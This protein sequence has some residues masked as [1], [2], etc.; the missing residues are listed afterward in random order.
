MKVLVCLAEAGEVVP[1]ERLIQTVWTDTF[2]TD[3]VLIRSISELR[4]VFNDDPKQ[5]HVIETIPK[6]GYRLLIPA[7]PVTSAPGN[8]HH[9][10][11]G[12][13]ASAEESAIHGPRIWRQWRWMWIALSAVIVLLVVLITGAWFQRFVDAHHWTARAKEGAVLAV[14]PFQN[15]NDDPDREYFA[16]GLTAEMISQLGRLPSDKISVIAWNSMRRYR[17]TKK[18]DEAI[19]AELRANYLLEG[20]VRR[21]G[22]HV[23]ITAEL[24]HV[25]DR[26]HIWANSYDGEL[27]DVLNLQTRLASEIAS[28]IRLSLTP[29]EQE[30]LA[31]TPT[32]N[33]EGYDAYLRGKFPVEG[34]TG[35]AGIRSN[36]ANLQRSI[37]L[38]PG[39]ASGYAALATQ[40]RVLSSYGWVPRN[41]VYGTMRDA[42]EMALK[43]DPD[44]EEA[45]HELA[46]L[47]WRFDWNFTGA[48]EEFK[49]AV[50]LNPSDAMAHSEYALLLKSLGRYDESLREGE[51]AL[52]S[53]PLDTYSLVNQ[54]TV[55]ALKGDY[56]AA[57]D[58]FSKVERVDPQSPY[59]HERLGQVLL[60]QKKDADAI[61]E[62]EAACASSHDQPEKLAWLA[63]ALAGSG[64]RDET[65]RILAKLTHLPKERYISPFHMSLPYIALGD[66][67][68]AIGWLEKAYQDHDEWLVYLKV[69]PEF[70]PLRDDP[71]F[72]SLV[73]RIGFQ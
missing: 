29:V 9:A 14:L 34:L 59:F 5:Q 3:D 57:M 71:R 42:L 65:E 72:V 69:Y 70:G 13:M 41:E 7:V 68:Q 50:R 8:G 56:V 31:K 45:H 30:Q 32:I 33:G 12:G 1:K 37:K 48:E 54:A 58:E 2:V 24:L 19:A 6:G 23:R 55:L 64:H 20:T 46:W 47:E 17:G 73:K 11:G 40:Y 44:N 28:D 38:N 35:D 61:R 4:K 18:G 26:S 53:S 15:L 51:R 22:D 39:Y 16:D 49:K 43:I 36:I 10:R 27:G 60:W 21:S 63:Y 62:F 66:R 67:D 52:Q 25:G